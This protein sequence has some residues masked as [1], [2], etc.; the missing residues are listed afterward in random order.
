MSVAEIEA[1]L[2]VGVKHSHV[3]PNRE[4]ERYLLN[5]I[6]ILFVYFRCAACIGMRNPAIPSHGERTEAEVSA[7]RYGR[8]RPARGQL[9]EILIPPPGPLSR[10]HCGMAQGS[11]KN[12]CNFYSRGR[13][14]MALSPGLDE[15]G[16]PRELTQPAR[17]RRRAAAV[18][19]VGCGD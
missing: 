17:E 19:H 5:D 9:W 4:Q 18:G 13:P 14:R 16:L 10:R 8:T 12:C 6:N 3:L 1:E 15:S 7:Q 11:P 2:S